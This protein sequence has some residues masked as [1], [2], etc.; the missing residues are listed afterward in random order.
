MIICHVEFDPSL[1]FQLKLLLQMSGSSRQTCMRCEPNPSTHREHLLEGCVEVLLIEFGA[2]AVG[3]D[4]AGLSV[5]D[6]ALRGCKR[7]CANV[8]CCM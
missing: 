3:D 2:E 6:G 4:R 8:N 5:I 7:I 1:L